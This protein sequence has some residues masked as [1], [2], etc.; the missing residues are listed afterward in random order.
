MPRSR[1]LAR[2]P[3]SPRDTSRPRNTEV[4][5]NSHLRGQVKVHLSTQPKKQTSTESGP[6][7]GGGLWFTS[8]DSPHSSVCCARTEEGSLSGS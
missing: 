2:A 3:G 6:K 8:D 1:H 4:R 7:R 5:E